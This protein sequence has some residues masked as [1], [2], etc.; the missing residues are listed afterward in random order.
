MTDPGYPPEATA[1]LAA[2]TQ[3][4]L[5]QAVVEIEQYVAAGGWDAPVRVFALVGT[6]RPGARSG[7]APD[8]LRTRSHADDAS[9][10]LGPTLVPGLIEALLSTFD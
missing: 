2:G 6:A 10:A 7:R 3:T 5:A 9:V 4:A 1:A 8:A